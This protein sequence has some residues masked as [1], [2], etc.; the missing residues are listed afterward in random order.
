MI[1]T[2]EGPGE[3]F[4]LGFFVC[5]HTLYLYLPMELFIPYDGLG[6]KSLAID[7]VP[8]EDRD[9]REAEK[10]KVGILP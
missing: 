6:F 8:E 5:G 4:F 3:I 2:I 9:R 1:R 10:K 7:I